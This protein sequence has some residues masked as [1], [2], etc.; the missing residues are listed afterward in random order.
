MRSIT[1]DIPKTVENTF[2][3]AVGLGVL[4]IGL[5]SAYFLSGIGS[6]GDAPSEPPPVMV[7]PSGVAVRF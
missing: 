4:S 3:T 1:D 2:Y 7:T 6:G 5:F